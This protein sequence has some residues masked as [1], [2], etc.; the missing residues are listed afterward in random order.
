MIAYLRGAE[1]VTRQVKREGV[2]ITVD[3]AKEMIET[4]FSEYPDTR[5]Y[6]ERCQRAV[7]DPGYVQTAFGRR[8]HFYML[9][10][11]D[12]DVIAA[13]GREAVN[14]PIQGTVADALSLALINLYNYRFTE[15]GRK[16]DYRIVAA[17]HDAIM[18]EAKEED[19]AEVSQVMSLCMTDQVVVPGVNKRLKTDEEIFIRWSE[20]E[21]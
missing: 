3:K 21:D 11:T 6:I 20:K 7:E 1:A 10:N 9:P 16:L 4:F 14:A 13:M 18:V 15:H 5:R 17:I 19:V 2:E 12:D 8:R